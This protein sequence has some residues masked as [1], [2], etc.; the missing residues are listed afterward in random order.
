MVSTTGTSFNDSAIVSNIGASATTSGL[1]LSTIV[2]DFETS[3]KISVSFDSIAGKSFTSFTNSATVS[4]LGASARASGL[5]IPTA[6]T[7]FTDSAIV[8]NSGAST[9][10]LGAMVSSWNMFYFS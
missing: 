3:A 10:T 7:S 2:S 6:G 5:M 9:T 1:M 8:S 4:N